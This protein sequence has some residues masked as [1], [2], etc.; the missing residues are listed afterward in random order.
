MIVVIVRNQ[1]EMNTR[2]TFEW[3]AGSDEPFWAGEGNRAGSFR[4][5]GI[6]ENIE[7]VELNEQ[8]GMADPCNRRISDIVSQPRSI[9]DDGDERTGPWMQCRGPQSGRNELQLIPFGR[10]SNERIDVL[11]TV[12]QPVTIRVSRMVHVL[13]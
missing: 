5:V 12:F 1:H 10:I 7:T 13:F 11:E 3:H 8:G 2:E 9:V 4:P 6:R